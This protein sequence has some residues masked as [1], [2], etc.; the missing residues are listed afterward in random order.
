MRGGA[1]SRG[2]GSGRSEGD[3]SRP[4]RRE[5]PRSRSP[6]AR[7]HS[8]GTAGTQPGFGET[9]VSLPE[10]RGAR[11]TPLRGLRSGAPPDRCG[12]RRPGRRPTPAPRAQRAAGAPG[13]A[14]LCPAP[15]SAWDRPELPS[16]SRPRSGAESTGARD[17][18]SRGRRPGRGG[19]PRGWGGTP[20]PGQAPGWAAARSV[21]TT[22]E[23]AGLPRTVSLPGLR[24]VLTWLP[25]GR[26][27]QPG[28]RGPASRGQGRR[29]G[30]ERTAARAAPTLPPESGVEH[31]ASPPRAN[32]AGSHGN[33]TTYLRA[34]NGRASQ[35]APQPGRRQRRLARHR[36]WGGA[37]GA[38]ACIP[39]GAPRPA[40]WNP[41]ALSGGT[42]HL[43]YRRGRGLLFFPGCLHVFLKKLT[44]T[45]PVKSVLP[46]NRTKTGGCF[47]PCRSS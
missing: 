29:P 31:S 11:V 4:A 9:R 20:H 3:T 37:P 35:P 34:R 36:A 44:T 14:P 25:A 32:E 16:R 7:A 41:G 47:D 40:P 10:R 2:A 46:T 17:V 30:V 27:Q 6:L 43:P 28:R 42:C 26:E 12:R 39:G 38:P 1:G 22:R 45:C 8:A 33:S 24:P 5:S 23:R 18:C 19:R 21:G 13:C 15:T